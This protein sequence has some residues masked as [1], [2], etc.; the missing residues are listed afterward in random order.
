MYSRH[1]EKS[2]LNLESERDWK[3]RGC[4]YRGRGPHL[5]VLNPVFLTQ[6]Q[7]FA[8]LATPLK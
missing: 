2:Y 5:H 1:C 8:M 6:V 3:R 7:T 4:D